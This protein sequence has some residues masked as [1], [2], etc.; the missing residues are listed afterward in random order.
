MGCTSLK[1]SVYLKSKCHGVS[2]GLSGQEASSFPSLFL[3]MP[4]KNSLQAYPG[5]RKL[6]RA[7]RLIGTFAK[8]IQLSSLCLPN[9]SRSKWWTV[10]P[11]CSPRRGFITVGA[12]CAISHHM[13]N[14]Q[15]VLW[16]VLVPTWNC[17]EACT[18]HQQSSFPARE[19]PPQLHSWQNCPA[20]SQ[21][22][23]EAKPSHLGAWDRS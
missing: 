9:A 6:G 7:D 5:R 15:A 11:R 22:P 8:L 3:K 14:P 12:A 16:Q 19:P 23:L 17:R 1:K 2:C 4:L 18:E 20:S 21:Q 10:V 13:S